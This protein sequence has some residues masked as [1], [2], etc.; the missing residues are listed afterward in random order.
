V[1]LAVELREV[2]VDAEES[3]C[4]DEAGQ[5]EPRLSGLG[6]ERREEG[7]VHEEVGLGVEVAADEG[8]PPGRPRQEAV[9]V[10]EQRLRLQEQGGPDELAAREQQRARE[11]DGRVRQHHRRR[12]H[13]EAEQAR[14]E[15]AGERPEDPGDDELGRRAVLLGTGEG[16]RRLVS[17]DGHRG[18]S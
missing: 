17:R 13:A 8:H 4:R 10:V 11:A 3:R 15:Q 16:R 9:G 7:S 18:R 14:H 12:R 5:R 6:A 1:G 2:E